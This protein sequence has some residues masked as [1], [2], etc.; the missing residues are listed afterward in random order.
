MMS[1]IGM[2]RQSI[3]GAAALFQHDP[4]RTAERMQEWQLSN[5]NP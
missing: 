2:L 3:Y 1:V 4:L 5:R